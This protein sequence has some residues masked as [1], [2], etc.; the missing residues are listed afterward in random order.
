MEMN[1]TRSRLKAPS[2]LSTVG[3]LSVQLQQWS[4]STRDKALSKADYKESLYNWK[5]N[6]SV[7][8]PETSQIQW[9]P[10]KCIFSLYT[11][12]PSALK[13]I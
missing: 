8:K 3:A 9:K 11:N 1:R 7:W 10:K 12:L 2:F 4:K 5:S 13:M 6:K